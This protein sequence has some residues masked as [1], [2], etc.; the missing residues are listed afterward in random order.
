VR[1]RISRSVV[2][3]AVSCANNVVRGPLD[4]R[5]QGQQQTDPDCEAGPTTLDYPRCAAPSARSNSMT[6]SLNLRDVSTVSFPP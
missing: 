2:G 1:A 5:V 6:L 4:A 3:S